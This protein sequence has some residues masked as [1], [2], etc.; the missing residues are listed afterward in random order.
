MKKKK[1]NHG[2]R[3]VGEIM[4]DMDTP[5]GDFDLTGQFARNGASAPAGPKASHPLLSAFSSTFEPVS[6]EH[7]AHE[8]FTTGRLREYFQ[9]WIVPKMPDPLPVYL[10]ELDCMGFAMRTSSFAMI[11]KRLTRSGSYGNSLHKSSKNLRLISST[12]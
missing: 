8:V 9:A 4:E 10:D 7:L 6:S 5:H 11:T 3:R 1:K 12:I 2:L